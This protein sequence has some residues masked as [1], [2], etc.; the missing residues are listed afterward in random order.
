MYVTPTSRP[1]L[2]GDDSPRSTFAEANQSICRAAA[3]RPPNSLSFGLGRRRTTSSSSA[4]P[5][6]PAAV[7]VE[8]VIGARVVWVWFSGWVH[9][10][11]WGEKKEGARRA[12]K[13]EEH[14]VGREHVG[15]NCWGGPVARRG[16][17][18]DIS[19]AAKFDR[20]S[21]VCARDRRADSLQMASGVRE[22]RERFVCGGS[23]QLRR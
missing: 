11:L 5:L 4:C 10:R 18:K 16:F 20:P 7:V 8:T 9:S 6:I 13:T 1:L 21:S 22:R 14:S 15:G 23:T 3:V 19:K 2:A 12:K 17:R